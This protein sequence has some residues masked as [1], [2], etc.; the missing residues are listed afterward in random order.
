MVFSGTI[1]AQSE[2]TRERREKEQAEKKEKK[3]KL[4]QNAVEKGKKLHLKK[5]TREVRRRM[6]KSLKESEKLRGN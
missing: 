5:Q 1:N 6:R 3:K 2:G 4:E